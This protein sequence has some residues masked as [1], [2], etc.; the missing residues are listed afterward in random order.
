[1]R[2]CSEA[3]IWF[4]ILGFRFY[5]YANVLLGL[6][7]SDFGFGYSFYLLLVTISIDAGLFHNSYEFT[8]IDLSITIFVELV[9]HSLQLII[10]KILLHLSSDTTQVS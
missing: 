6:Q 3:L 1:M 5:S 7:N 8:L 2:E 9:D 10:T 4:F